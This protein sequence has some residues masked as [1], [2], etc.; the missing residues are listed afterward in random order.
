MCSSLAAKPK[1]RFGGQ[2]ILIAWVPINEMWPVA[3]MKLIG[4][5]RASRETSL[6][7]VDAAEQY[8]HSKIQADRDQ[9]QAENKIGTKHRLLFA[10]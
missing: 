6:R 3:T 10:R 8:L 2:L 9:V 5:D 7:K 4:S 1:R